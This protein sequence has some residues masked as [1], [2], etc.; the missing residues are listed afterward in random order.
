[1]KEAEERGSGYGQE[2]GSDE[3]EGEKE[4]MGLQ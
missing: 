3:R 1:M 4:A 2:N